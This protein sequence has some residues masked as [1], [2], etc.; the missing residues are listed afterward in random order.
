LFVACERSE[1][2]D[3]PTE[4][5]TEPFGI[6]DGGIGSIDRFETDF[7]SMPTY[8]GGIARAL[9]DSGVRVVAGRLGAGKSLY[10]RMMRKAQLE[11]S[12]V[13]ADSPTR[14]LADLS[15]ADVVSFTRLAGVKG[16]NSEA[17]KT[18]WR[19]AI[20]RSASS[21][22]L[23]E[24]L[25]NSSISD[26]L[27]AEVRSYGRLLGQPNR[28]RRVTTEASHIVREHAARVELRDYL[29]D[30][31]WSDAEGAV[32]EAIS[33]ARP[34]FL[35]VDA[36]DDNFRWAPTQ[37]M[38][39]QRGLYYA[40]LDLLREGEGANRLHVVIA[41][42][43]IV[44]GST[45][46]SEHTPRY[47]ERTHINILD[48]NRKSISEFLAHKVRRLP[49]AFF[50]DPRTKT[51]ASWLSV[52]E[53]T[54]GRPNPSLEPIDSY[55]IRH[56]RMV[57]RDIVV[58][59]NRLCRYVLSQRTQHAEISE[60]DLRRE[61]ARASRE[62]ASS[63]LAQCA[64]Q[65]MSDTMPETAVDHDF[66]H[67][68]LEPN[69]YQMTEA[70]DTICACIGTVGAE[71][72]GVEGISTLDDMATDGF[73][74]EVRLANILWQNGLVG[75]TRNGWAHYYSLEDL[76][77]SALPQSK[78]YVFNPILFDRVVGLRP[79]FESPLPV[80]T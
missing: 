34:L 30:P 4:D 72:F 75:W 18:L 52:A 50:E 35:Y 13:Y 16:G 41:L 19:R 22:V 61:V 25:L 79:S 1:G 78:R 47:L 45:R 63:Q 66:T 67:V 38:R 55:L 17:W 44:L 15:T 42:R 33:S 36:I 40:I 10:L 80:A 32:L 54:N 48:W 7:I 70:V 69:E 20:F 62:F 51:V 11:N 9:D 71:E 39:C 68:Y 21:F 29:Q 58:M 64:N 76:A 56:T 14:N 23:T 43:D 57:P 59:G 6:P 24:P 60:E 49:D 65:V 28:K 12:S 2:G 8:Y 31:E 53:I 77:T 37:W 73:G 3:M 74:A 27:L 46:A 26:D 5:L